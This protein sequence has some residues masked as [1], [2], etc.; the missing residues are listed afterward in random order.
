MLASL[1]ELTKQNPLQMGHS[2]WEI[3]ERSAQVY[4]FKKFV[5]VGNLSLLRNLEKG[6]GDLKVSQF[7][8]GDVMEQQK[9]NKYA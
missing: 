3:A 5:S 9:F 7:L 1:H 2:F 4:C 6:M 8:K